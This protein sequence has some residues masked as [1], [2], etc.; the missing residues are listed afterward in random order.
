MVESTIARRAR[1]LAGPAEPLESREE[2]YPQAPPAAH[3]LDEC[4]EAIIEW[5]AALDPAWGDRVKVLRDERNL[6]A[7]QALGSM[8]GYVLDQ[9]LHMIVPN[10]PAFETTLREA[11]EAICR[12]PSCGKPFSRRYPGEPFHSNECAR[13]W[14]A[15]HGAAAASAA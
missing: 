11:Q 15:E 3:S 7:K 4:A 14:H 1:E 6:S 8:V 5:V 9:S 2:K 10:N 13:A 12:L